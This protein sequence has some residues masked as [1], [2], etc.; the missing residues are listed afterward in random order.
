MPAPTIP[1]TAPP[2]TARN[3]LPTDEPS[4]RELS[5][6]ARH[7][8]QAVLPLISKYVPKMSWGQKAQVRGEEPL[9]SNLALSKRRLTGSGFSMAHLARVETTRKSDF[10]H[11]RRIPLAVSTREIGR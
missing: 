11:Y 9:S 1:P 4:V 6:L 2:R 10:I 7:C 3:A 8:L 5:T